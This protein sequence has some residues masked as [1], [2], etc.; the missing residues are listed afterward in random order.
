MDNN[1]PNNNT[2]NQPAAPAEP[3]AKAPTTRTPAATV[4]PVSIE[5]P[6]APTTETTPTPPPAPDSTTAEATPVTPKNKRTGLITGLIA[7]A[8]LLIC[9]GAFAAF[10]IIKNQPD[11]ILAE[12]FSNLVNA[13]RVAL[14]GTINYESKGDYSSVGP[15]AVTINS[16]LSDSN[17]AS[18]T[19]LTLNI[20]GLD[21]AI[22]LSLGEVY[23]QDGVLY[24]KASGLTKL[25]QDIGSGALGSYLDASSR[26]LISN[27]IQ[28]I[29][30][31]WFRISLAEI[32]D[33]DLVNQFL[34]SEEKE[35]ITKTY[36]CTRDVYNNLSNYSNEF[37]DLY[38]DN[39]F[40]KLE[41]AD[42]S[43]YKV[44][45]IAEPFTNYLKAIPATKVA[46][47][48]LACSGINNN[49]DTSNL[50]TSNVSSEL[51]SAPDIYV[52]FDGFLNHHLS[53][54]KV[55]KEETY[56]ATKADLKFAYPSDIVV[57]APADSTPVM[58][59]VQYIIDESSSMNSRRYYYNY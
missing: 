38:S 49:V 34:S 55:E 23:M 59:L 30:D 21:E 41:P 2:P 24:L 57:T 35:T 26:S 6:V 9:G 39:Q 50:T 5:A 56:F 15:V 1:P 36:N 52:K 11:N 18:D 3:A 13:K 28:K 42:N 58:E 4:T 48:Y 46:Q 27:I 14:S 22:E 51:E 8:V 16:K 10:A 44:T 7:L 25:Y 19:S 32:L 37:A 33:S 47:D 40:I 53:E 45:L 12:S 20:E 54:L 43:F 29:D 31:Q 17:L